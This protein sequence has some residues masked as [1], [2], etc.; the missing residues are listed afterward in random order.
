M[1]RGLPPG[2]RRR[3]RLQRGRT[4]RSRVQLARRSG[5]GHG[6][7][8]RGPGRGS[9]G[10]RRGCRGRKRR[11]LR[12]WHRRG[13]RRGQRIGKRW[14]RERNGERRPRTDLSERCGRGGLGRFG[15]PPPLRDQRKLPLRTGGRGGVPQRALEPLARD[16]RR[17]GPPGPQTAE[18]RSPSASPV[19]SLTDRI[20][21]ATLASSSVRW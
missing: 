15:S 4:G 18:K 7:R 9:S 13:L 16:A 20:S 1:E 19:R 10:Q 14:R 5:R 2:L 3:R 21:S 12:R 8:S 17:Y 11:R 6:L